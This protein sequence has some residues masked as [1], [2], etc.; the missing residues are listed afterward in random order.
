[1]AQLHPEWSIVFIGLVDDRECEAMMNRLRQM[2][3]V[4][5]LGVKNITKVPY[6]VKGFDVGIIPYKID[7]ETKSLNALKLFD[8]MAIG[9]PIVTT[10]IPAVTK[11]KNVVRIADSKEKFAKHIEN[12]LIGDDE[13]TVNKRRGVASQNTW[14]NRVV[15][16]SRLIDNRLKKI[17]R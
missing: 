14:E 7:E 6:Y 9:M 11:F 4:H 8:F 5:F 3:N 15:H 1:M 17:K 10:G 2:K 16:L 13:N 12:A